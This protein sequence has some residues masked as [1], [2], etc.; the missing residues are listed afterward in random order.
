M[1]LKQEKQKLFRMTEKRNIILGRASRSL[2]STLDSNEFRLELLAT[3]QNLDSNEQ[4]RRKSE[5]L[6]ERERLQDAHDVLTVVRCHSQPYL[7][8]IWFKKER[9]WRTEWDVPLDTFERAI[10]LLIEL[11]E[12]YKNRTNNPA[13]RYDEPIQL[14]LALLAFRKA[15]G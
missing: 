12:A 1:T 9:S 7:V 11:L 10:N 15:E 5:L 2:E 14:L 3:Q 4:S 6:A 8:D 13:F